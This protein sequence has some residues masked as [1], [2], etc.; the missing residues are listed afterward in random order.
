MG[1]VLNILFCLSLLYLA[2]TTRVTAYLQVFVLQS[3]LLFF[4]VMMPLLNHLSVF[5]LVLPLT[6]LVVKAILIPR[7]MKKKI[8]YELEI[9]TTI[10][11]NIQQFNFLLLSVFSMVAV[12]VS[13]NLITKDA[14][15]DPIPFAAA[16]SSVVIGLYVI[17]FRKKLIV[18]VIGFLVME[19]GIFLLG[20]A[21]ASEMPFLIELGILLDIFVVV[22]LMGI[23]INKIS[24]TF[25]ADEVSALDKLKN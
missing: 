14:A 17:I 13:C 20:I 21:V 9:K 8:I 10:E 3:I 12:F 22:F 15:V 18:H 5:T 2:T 16:F 24:S 1:N 4:I 11:A 6:I 25:A 7:Y 19:N 23:A